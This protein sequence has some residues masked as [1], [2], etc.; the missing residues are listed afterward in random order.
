[1]S[2]IWDILS[3][4]SWDN[5]L[6]F[7]VALNHS[8]CICFFYFFYFGSSG[9]GKKQPL[10]PSQRVMHL[11]WNKSPLWA[12]YALPSFQLIQWSQAEPLYPVTPYYISTEPLFSKAS[13]K[14]LAGKPVI[15]P[16]AL[17][18]QVS[19]WFEVQ[20]S[21]CLSSIIWHHLSHCEIISLE[22]WTQVSWQ[23][24]TR[25]K[26]QHKLA[27]KQW[28]KIQSDFM[29]HFRFVQ[30]TSSLLQQLHGNSKE[31]HLWMDAAWGRLEVILTDSGFL[32]GVEGFKPARTP[33]HGALLLLLPFLVK[34]CPLV[35][36][37]PLF[38]LILPLWL[39]SLLSLSGPHWVSVSSVNSPFPLSLW[40]GFP[41]KPLLTPAN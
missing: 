14:A 35:R 36:V 1:M 5:S 15:N 34:S 25:K 2:I 16:P 10:Q 38:R 30:W 29:V 24:L 32:V 40:Q 22:S 27:P 21:E 4:S 9:H 18:P 41:K 26:D 23:A 28:N 33:S 20:W 19:I 8:C 7:A 13:D 11:I 31:L 3:L 37:W 17:Y 39:T 6:H 12:H